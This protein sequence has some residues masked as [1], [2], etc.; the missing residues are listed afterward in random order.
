MTSKYTHD[1]FV[2]LIMAIKH[3]IVQD[4]FTNSVLISPVSEDESLI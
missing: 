3:T 4:V 1:K 2:N